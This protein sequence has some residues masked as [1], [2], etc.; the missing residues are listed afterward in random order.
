MKNLKGVKGLIMPVTNFTVSLLLITCNA[1]MQLSI[2]QA[3]SQKGNQL[4]IAILV[5]VQQLYKSPS[6][7][8][9]SRHQTSSIPILTFTLLVLDI[10][11]NMIEHIVH[12]TLTE[13][14][15]KSEKEKHVSY[16]NNV[17]S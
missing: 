5:P 9:F 7:G 4:Y 3:F 17:N 6:W 1:H 2:S 16:T 13:L 11:I 15:L 10:N 14:A 12:T 8:N